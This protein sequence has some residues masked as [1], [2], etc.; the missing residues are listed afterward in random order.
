MVG[1][2]GENMSRTALQKVQINAVCT[3]ALISREFAGSLLNDRGTALKGY[4]LNDKTRKALM[5]IEANTI[6][7]FIEGARPLIE[8]AKKK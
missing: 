2:I 8:R 4:P 7:E 1:G 3:R 6:K 5:G